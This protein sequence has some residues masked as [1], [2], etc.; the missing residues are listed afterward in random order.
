MRKIFV[1]FF[2]IVVLLNV[3]RLWLGEHG[4]VKRTDVADMYVPKFDQGA[5]FWKNPSDNQ[6]DASILR[7]APAHVGSVQPQHLCSILSVFMPASLAFTIFQILIE[8]LILA[9]TYVFFF[10]FLGYRHLSAIYGS[11]FHLSMFYWFNENP[12]VTQ[13]FLVVLF[14]AATSI[15]RRP[16]G[17]ITR[18]LLLLVSLFISYP[19]YTVPMAPMVHLLAVVLLSSKERRGI[20]IMFWCGFWAVY[21][22]FYWPNLI[23]YFF[24]WGH[25]NR[26]IWVTAGGVL[27]WQNLW[28]GIRQMNFWFPCLAVVALFQFYKIPVARWVLFIFVLIL[29]FISQSAYFKTIPIFNITSFAWSRLSFYSSV[30]M[31][32]LIIYLI[33]HHPIKISKKI[34]AGVACWIIVAVL[35]LKSQ[36]ISRSVGMMYVVFSLLSIGYVAFHVLEKAKTPTKM[37][38]L[39]L[40]FL[41]PCKIY[42]VKHY[43]DVPYG[44]LYQD[45]FKYEH[46]LYPYRVVTLSDECWHPAF[47]PAQAQMRGQETFDGVSV[48][49]NKVD[50]ANWNAYVI[51]DADYCSFKGWNNRVEL[52]RATWDQNVDAIL[53]WLRLN[54][55]AFIRSSA[56]IT[57]PSLILQEQVR[58]D[59]PKASKFFS[60]YLLETPDHFLYRIKDPASRIFAVAQGQDIK[61]ETFLAFERVGLDAYAPSHMSWQGDFEGKDLMAS[62]NYHPD[63]KVKVDGVLKEDALKSG[64]FGMIHIKPVA[65]VHRYDL[66]FLGKIYRNICCSMFFAIFVLIFLLHT[67]RKKE[68]AL[69]EA[70]V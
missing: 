65:G 21:A 38:I 11:L 7:G 30:L 1:M 8:F 26:T 17:G 14:I 25:S 35:A 32:F 46:T 68:G 39:C 53:G 42:S 27:S 37:L 9:G 54:N 23:G 67:L 43:E 49:Y 24:T 22:C 60:P 10:N 36:W 56:P 57:H 33:E 18:F 13:T 12:F 63:W 28:D 3:P 2:L 31:L 6:W 4:P 19:P 29:I 70:A 40:I 5:K 66:V 44:Y 41:L 69:H 16:I 59:F 55:T 61:P 62:I 48:F 20:N 34:V 58:V 64:P 47:Y 15:G 50:A 45:Q 52:V 51:K